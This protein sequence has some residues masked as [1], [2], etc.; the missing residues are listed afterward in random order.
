MTLWVLLTLAGSG[1]VIGFLSGLVGIGGGV[2]IVPLL[3][4]FYG[5]AGWSGVEVATELH[6]VVA[7]ATSLFVIAPT[8]ALG[9][10]TYHRAGAVAWRS[11]LPI[12]AFSV[13]AALTGSQLAAHVPAPLLKIAFGALLLVSGVRLLRPRESVPPPIGRSR[14]AVG[15][16]AGLAVGLLSALLG[17]GGGIIAIPILIYFVGLELDK[18]AASS[19]AIIVFTAL[20]AVVGYGF[21]GL[22]EAGLPPGSI[23]YVHVLAG[24]PIL[25]GALIAVSAGARA[26]QRLDAEKLRLLFGGLFIVLGLR[27]LIQNIPALTALG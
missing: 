6:A 1:V 4:F 7:H 15:A 10:W 24:L 20:A 22:G 17:V 19:M 2:L 13:I 14:I 3:Y 16:V 12:A 8:S 18:V 25:A 5:H 21:A 9:T 27:L 26:N 11:A 23:G